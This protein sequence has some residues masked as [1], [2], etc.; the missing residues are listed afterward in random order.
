MYKRGL[1]SP[2]RLRE[3]LQ[4]IEPEL[5]RFPSIDPDALKSRVYNFLDSLPE[6]DDDRT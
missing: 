2:D 1:F 3:C 4:A 5:I 6:H